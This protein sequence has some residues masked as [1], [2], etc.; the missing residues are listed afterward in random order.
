MIAMDIR[1]HTQKN[2][3]DPQKNLVTS[4]SLDRDDLIDVLETLPEDERLVI[5]LPAHM[6]IFHSQS[7]P[8]LPRLPAPRK[9]RN[10]TLE[11]MFRTLPV[12]GPTRTGKEEP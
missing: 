12:A 5:H 4:I 9:V 10:I 6:R 8:T 7:N 3:L 11:K 1:F 2:R